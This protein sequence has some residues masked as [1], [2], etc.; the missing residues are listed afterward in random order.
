M[1]QK[2]VLLIL[3]F[4]DYELQSSRLPG[5]STSNGARQADV[6]AHLLPVVVVYTIQQQY[7]LSAG[8]ILA[9]LEW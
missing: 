7:Q 3:Y 8:L 6:P 9:V 2:N 1:L 4:V 5:N